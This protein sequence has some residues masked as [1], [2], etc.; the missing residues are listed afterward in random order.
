MGAALRLFVTRSGLNRR[1]GQLLSVAGQGYAC[2]AGRYRKLVMLFSNSGIGIQ[3]VLEGQ[4]ENMRRLLASA[5][6]VVAVDAA[7]GR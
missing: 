4:V 3:A 6:A 5:L 2:H 1:S 7:R